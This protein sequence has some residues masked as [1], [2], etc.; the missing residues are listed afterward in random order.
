MNYAYAKVFLVFLKS[1]AHFEIFHS[2]YNQFHFAAPA[3][4]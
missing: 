3:V 4:V 1:K 2:Y